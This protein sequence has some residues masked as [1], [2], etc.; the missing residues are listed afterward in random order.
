MRS[1]YDRTGGNHTADASTSSIR[2]PTISTSRSTS[3]APASSTSRATTTGTAAHGTT[4][5]TA[6]T[7]SSRRPAPPIPQSVPDSVFLPAARVPAAAHLDLVDHQGRRPDVGADSVRAVVPHGVLAD[8]LRTGYYIYHQF[9]D[10]TPLSRPIE[11][12]DGETPP[13]SDVL[14][15]VGRAG[16]DIAPPAGS[17][18]VEEEKRR[19]RPSG[20]QEQGGVA[21]RRA[22]RG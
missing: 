8:V 2:R 16:S 15:L 5:S 3:Q 6:G 10:G 11:S 4:R 7:T 9:V 18:G 19:A 22:V 21:H 13:S 17:D 14:E 12:W 20:R 1:T